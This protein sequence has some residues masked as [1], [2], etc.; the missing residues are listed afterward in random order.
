MQRVLKITVIKY[1]MLTDL[2]ML[3][4]Y[5]IGVRGEI[6]RVL[7][8]YAEANNKYIPDYDKSKE[9]TY[10]LFLDFSNQF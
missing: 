3:L 2:N 1:K 6:T 4:D 10:V 9:S 5:E 8:H 7:R